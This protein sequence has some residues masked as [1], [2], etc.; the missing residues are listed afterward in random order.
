MSKTTAKYR[1]GKGIKR[2]FVLVEKL[3]EKESERS[4]MSKKTEKVKKFMK[5]ENKWSK[6][7]LRRKIREVKNVKKNSLKR[8]KITF[9]MVETQLKETK[10]V[11]EVQKVRKLTKNIFLILTTFE[12]RSFKR[13]FIDST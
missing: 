9:T 11:Y 8:S 6:S 3:F 10:K 4:K 12:L 13:C 2:P 1:I 5:S 7:S